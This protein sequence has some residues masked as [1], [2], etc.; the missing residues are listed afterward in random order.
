[1]SST[2]TPCRLAMF[3]TRLMSSFITAML[4]W[5]RATTGDSVEVAQLRRVL[6]DQPVLLFLAQR[7]PPPVD[8]FGAL[9]PGV[10]EESESGLRVWQEIPGAPLLG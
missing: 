1:M 5:L 7:I 2:D 10:G 9:C 4:T 3:S 6:G 8:V